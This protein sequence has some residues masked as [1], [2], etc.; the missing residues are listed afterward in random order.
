[1]TISLETDKKPRR[2]TVR[3]AGANRSI[4][5]TRHELDE[6]GNP[7]SIEEIELD[8]WLRSE[9]FSTPKDAGTMRKR[10]S[11]IFGEFLSNLPD[12]R[13][14]A[15]RDEDAAAARND[16]EETQAKKITSAE[17]LPEH[18]GKVPLLRPNVRF[19]V[20]Q[21]RK[22]TGGNSES[23]QE[24]SERG[25][26][27]S[28]PEQMS[29]GKAEKASPEK[30]ERLKASAKAYSRWFLGTERGGTGAASPDL[31]RVRSKTDTSPGGMPKEEGETEEKRLM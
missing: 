15:R 11:R 16:G 29:F 10:F 25:Q 23:L 5:R 18:F 6:A 12:S 3:L 19:L 17:E 8:S 27:A 2:G 9:S 22:A 1:M 14:K 21:Q 4:T 26:I 13:A 7:K 20:E 31:A 30:H 28:K 24:S